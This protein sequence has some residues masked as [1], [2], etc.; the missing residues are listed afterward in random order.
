MAGFA[1]FI[2]SAELSSAQTPGT[3][4]TLVQPSTGFHATVTANSSGIYLF[5][6]V[7]PGTYTLTAAAKG[8]AT[9][10]YNGVVV[11]AGQ[12]A[13]VK[14]Q[15]QIG[16]TSQTVEV[17][18]SQ[19][20]ETTE[21]TLATT[22]STDLIQNLPLA[23]LD[24]LPFAQLVPAAQVGGDQRFTTFNSMPNGVINISVDGADN[25]FQRF[26]TSTTAFFEAAGLQLGAIQE[27]TVSTSD[28][29]AEAGAAGATTIAFTTKRGTNQF[30]GSAFWEAYNS[31][32]N[33][34]SFQNDAYLAAG[35]TQL[36][37]KQPFHTND[38][39][40]NIGGPIR[41]NKCSFSS[42]SSGRTSHQRLFTR[43]PCCPRPLKPV[44][45]HTR[46]RTTAS[47]RPLIS[48]ISRVML[49]QV[50]FPPPSTPTSKRF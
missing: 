18:A 10:A 20:L 50:P 29:N 3:T 30:H 48:S 22:V 21:N 32:F 17:S 43:R 41:K 39:G 47:S 26:R 27:V 6:D 13:N 24:A 8:F 37:R 28:L 11:T 42:I 40:A 12:T 16:A 45:S 31:A 46:V 34:N 23:G 7:L 14:V 49:Q 44:I 2:C 15:L 19:V 4:L 33:A 9:K 38:F 1:T 36:G 25:N 35:L 5:A